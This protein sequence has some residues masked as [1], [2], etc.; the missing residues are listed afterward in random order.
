MCYNYGMTSAECRVA[1]EGFLPRALGLTRGALAKACAEMG[2]DRIAL[3]HHRDDVLETLMMSLLYEGRMHTFRPVTELERSGVT[4]IRPMVFLSEKEI[5]RA[6]NRLNLPVVKSPCPVDGETRRHEMKQLLD[7][8][9]RRYPDAREK[10]LA[11]L[12]NH[13]QYGLWTRD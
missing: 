11:A 4:Q 10:M 12:M 3:G 9:S 7:D 1:V 8:L 2:F 5:I 13:E 6:Q